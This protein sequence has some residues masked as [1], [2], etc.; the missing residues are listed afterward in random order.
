MFYVA[1]WKLMLSYC[2]AIYYN[3]EFA[4]KEACRMTY[5]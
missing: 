4:M 5:G 2:N 3:L 1:L